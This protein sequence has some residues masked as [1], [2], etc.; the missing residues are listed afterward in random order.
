MDIIGDIITGHDVSLTA[1]NDDV[2]NKG[3][4]LESGR[5]MTIQA[6]RDVTVVPTEVASSLFSG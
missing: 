2:I 3:S 4:V 1:I 5:D 6:S